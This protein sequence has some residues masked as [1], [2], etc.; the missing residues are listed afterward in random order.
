[1]AFHTSCAACARSS[2][3]AGFPMQS[4]VR[5][6]GNGEDVAS[7]LGRLLAR[8]TKTDTATTFPGRREAAQVATPSPRAEGEAFNS[9]GQ[10]AKASKFASVKVGHLTLELGA[11]GTSESGLEGCTGC[12]GRQDCVQSAAALL[13]QLW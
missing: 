9:A 3:F 7:R 5:G 6:G 10:W 8:P 11:V 13:A 2:K 12:R 4:R 1:M